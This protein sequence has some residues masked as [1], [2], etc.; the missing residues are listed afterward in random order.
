MTAAFNNAGVRCWSAWCALVVA[1]MTVG[2]SAQAAQTACQYHEV[3]TLPLE[4]LERNAAPVIQGSIN[5]QPVQMLLDSGAQHTYLINA[6]MDRQGLSMARQKRQIAGVGG[7]ASM[8]LVRIRD[9]AVGPSHVSNANFSVVDALDQ[10]SFAAIVGADFLSQADMEVSLADKQAR[11]FHADGC[12][13]QGLA[14]WDSNALD[15]PMDSMSLK[16][17]RQIIE[18]EV[19]GQKVRATIDTGAASSVLSLEA[20]G[21]AG[22][23][24]Q[25]AGVAP[26]GIMTGIGSEKVPAYNA[27]FDSFTIGGETINNPHIRIA[28]WHLTQW[29]GRNGPEMLL[30][31]D[32]L[33]THRVLLA[34]SQHKLYF[35]Y[36]GG[37]VFLSPPAAA[38]MAPETG[39]GQP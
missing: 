3:A 7:S 29:F 18:V 6:E 4:L 17:Q 1:G 38:A 35:S 26:A 32:F 11:F 13:D 39:R 37:Q 5:G 24:P 12:A 2:V 22:I 20:A 30:G 9:M 33:K 14:Y 19:N 8:F 27:P 28:D 34:M 10:A 23:T 16:D 15:I 31:R 25:S 36:L 21:R